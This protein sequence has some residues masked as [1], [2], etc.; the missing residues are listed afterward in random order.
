MAIA[1]NSKAWNIQ[2]EKVSEFLLCTTGF[3][4][5]L[6]TDEESRA[7][8]HDKTIYINSRLHPEKKFYTTLHEIGHVLIHKNS[9][10]FERDYPMYVR[11]EDYLKRGSKKHRVS[12]IAEE[13]EAWRLG[14]ETARDLGMVIN[15]EKYDNLMAEN[16]TSYIVWAV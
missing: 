5:C 14:R 10:Q 13:I 6:K 4:L 8:F 11:P 9:K 3:S 1:M 15:D 16:V 12:I 7:S 2:I